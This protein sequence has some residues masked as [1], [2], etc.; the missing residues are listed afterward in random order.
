METV[1]PSARSGMPR[2][3]THPSFVPLA[4]SFRSLHSSIPLR[5]HPP[6]REHASTAQSMRVLDNL[7]SLFDPI[8]ASSWVVPRGRHGSPDS[9]NL[10]KFSAQRRN[11]V[12]PSLHI[13]DPHEHSTD[14]SRQ[15]DPIRLPNSLKHIRT[16]WPSGSYWS[17]RTRS[18]D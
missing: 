4:K 2:K 3:F 18:P 11:D 15:Q 16:L 10:T 1:S 9:S 13:R 8:A 7:V 5:A 12:L 17:F 6:T 14:S